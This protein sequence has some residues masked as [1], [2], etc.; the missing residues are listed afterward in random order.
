MVTGRDKFKEG[1]EALGFTVELQD[2]DKVIVPYIIAEGR[3]AKKQIRLGI[4]VPPDFE[5][6]PPAGIHISP[7]LI[8]MNPQ[9]NDHGR[10]AASAPFGSEFQ[11][12]SRPYHEWPLKRTVK[13]YMEYVTY[14]LNIL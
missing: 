9:V 3:F 13:R 14:L 7:H 1:L 6:T 2:P 11:Y 5:I 10:A 8:P 12:L 4:Q